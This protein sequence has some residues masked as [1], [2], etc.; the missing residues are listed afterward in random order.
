MTP[1][2]VVSGA[3]AA[4]VWPVHRPRSIP[5]RDFAAIRT[6]EPALGWS[7]RQPA[8]ITDCSPRLLRWEAA[9]QAN[10]HSISEACGS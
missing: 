2:P 4:L 7:G 1:C 6:P 9:L 10:R 8:E 3:R 5:K